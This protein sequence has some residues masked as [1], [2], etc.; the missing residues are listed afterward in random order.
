MP[1]GIGLNANSSIKATPPFTLQLYPVGGVPQSVG[2]VPASNEALTWRANYPAGTS[3]LLQFVDAKGYT[4]GV[5]PL[6]TITSGSSSCPLADDTSDLQL[7]Y[8]TTNPLT[9][10]QVD[11]DV[12]GGSPPYTVSI[13]KAADQGI[14]ITGVESQV[15][16]TNDATAGASFLYSACDSSGDCAVIP[17][18]AFSQ[19]G[20]NTSCIVG[21][22][23]P[24]QKPGSSTS[25]GHSKTLLGAVIAASIAAVVLLFGVGYLL[26][27][28]RKNQTD[29]SNK[30]LSFTNQSSP[31]GFTHLNSAGNRQTH[32]SA[33]PTEKWSGNTAGGSVHSMQNMTAPA[34]K[35]R[36]L[37]PDIDSDDLGYA[38]N[39]QAVPKS[40][41]TE[42]PL[43]EEVSDEADW[44]AVDHATSATLSHQTSA[45][46]RSG[47]TRAYAGS[48][49]SYVS[50]TTSTDSHGY[51]TR[52]DEGP[53]ADPRP[54]SA[55]GYS[56]QLHEDN[57]SIHR[58]QSQRYSA[59]R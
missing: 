3:L 33:S 34:Y 36:V 22:A 7:S 46:R 53:F 8:S 47:S 29:F 39:T 27:R 58:T 32:F 4:G 59:G 50:G 55:D 30:R 48:Y 37:N 44:T 43:T 23:K 51:W 17:A 56:E 42:S 16:W 49:T 26:Y 14:N 19:G 5:S 2:A 31:S 35:F 13:V 38:I 20:S 10:S 24:G 25:Q 12:S 9:C 52:E 21:S 40:R 45:K 6:T 18:V 54:E 41:S 28:R 1:F 57:E 11:L 15:S